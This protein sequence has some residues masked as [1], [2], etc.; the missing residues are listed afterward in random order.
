MTSN[1]GSRASIQSTRLT[2]GFMAQILCSAITLPI[3]MAMTNLSGSTMLGYFL[4]ALLFSVLTVPL[5]II[6][7]KVPKER[8][9]LPRGEMTATWGQRLSVFATLPYLTCTVGFLGW[10]LF[11]GVFLSGRSYWYRY[12]IGQ[13]ELFTVAMTLWTVGLACGAMSSGFLNRSIF[14]G[15]KKFTPMFGFGLSGLICVLTWFFDWRG[16]LTIYHVLTFFI[17]WG[18]GIGLTGFYAMVPDTNEYVQYYKG[19]RPSAFLGAGVN[20]VMKVGIAFSGAFLGFYLAGGGYVPNADVQAPGAIAAIRNS[21][22]LIAGLPLILAAVFA[23][24]NPLSTKKHQELLRKL[25]R[26]EYAPGVKPA[27]GQG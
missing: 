22:S 8:I 1:A 15:N 17:G 5:A 4:A 10:G 26:G 7:Y 23:V 12:Y 11:S 19:I 2:M 9:I 3:I 16:A 21:V 27:G 6:G 14:K 13:F 20:F 24:F 25:E 18:N